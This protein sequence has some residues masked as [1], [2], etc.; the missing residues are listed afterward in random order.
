MSKPGKTTYGI[1]E[2]AH[3]SMLLGKDVQFS[4]GLRVDVHRVRFAISH[5]EKVAGL[6]FSL[7]LS[8]HYL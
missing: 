1:A 8:Y 7:R 6:T 4:K 2:S 3:W 5:V